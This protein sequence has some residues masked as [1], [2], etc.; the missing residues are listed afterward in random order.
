MVDRIDYNM[1]VALVNV[2]KGNDQLIQARDRMEKG[3]VAKLIKAL[4]IA[5][6]ILFCLLRAICR[7]Q[8]APYSLAL[9]LYLECKQNNLGLSIGALTQ[10]QKSENPLP[11]A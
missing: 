8:P 9:V 1:E 4:F 11:G 3:C 2:E 6:V 10:K 5:N 7:D